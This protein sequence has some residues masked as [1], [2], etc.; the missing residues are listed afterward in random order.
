[1]HS[2]KTRSAL[3]HF[4]PLLL[5]RS[6]RLHLDYPIRLVWVRYA[7]ICRFTCFRA[8]KI[9]WDSNLKGSKSSSSVI[10][11]RA[12]RT[13][14]MIFIKVGD[15]KCSMRSTAKRFYQIY[16]AG[17]RPAVTVKDGLETSAQRSGPEKVAIPQC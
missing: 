9:L 3:Q 16:L 6:W 15:T 1:M 17:C 11:K 13:S 10:A 7:P 8:A 12:S 2:S 4:S 5:H 14:L